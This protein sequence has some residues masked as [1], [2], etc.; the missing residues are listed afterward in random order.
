MPTLKNIRHEQF[1]QELVQSQRHG[2]TRGSAYS[3]AGYR[4]EG[5]S[6]ESAAWRLLK[7]V[8]N[9]IAARVAEIVGKGAKR[10]EVTVESLLGELD[11]VLAGAVDDRQFGAA[12]AAIDSKA[13]LKGLFIDR[14]EV[15]G[16]GSFAACEDTEA[17]IRQLMA[18]MTPEAALALTD[19]MRQAI[20]RYA[21][22]HATVVDAPPS[23]PSPG[24][25]TALVP[26]LGHR[27][28]RTTSPRR[29]S[30]SLERAGQ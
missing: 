24:R 16:A 13:R 20:E 29:P 23:V 14:L 5:E 9:G 18:E 3:R 12:R 27:L 8:E 10:A 2:G 11:H 22:D 25:E 6:A 4:A 28:A 21:S 17:V 30:R 15:G 26:D 1:A 19:Q 7:N